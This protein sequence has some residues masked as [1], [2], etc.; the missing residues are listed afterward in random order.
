MVFLVVW[1]N[2]DYYLLLI[3]IDKGHGRGV[4]LIGMEEVVYHLAAHYSMALIEEHM[5][6]LFPR[7]QLGVKLCKILPS[8]QRGYEAVPSLVLVM[9]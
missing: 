6:N 7:I 4:R 8:R 5:P 1:P 9:R 2:S 3:P